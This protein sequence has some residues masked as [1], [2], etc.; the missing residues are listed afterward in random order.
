MK[1]N[2]TAVMLLSSAVSLGISGCASQEVKSMEV[3]L[4]QA[5]FDIRTADTDKKLAHLKRLQQN[6]LVLRKNDG[7]T[8]YYYADIV[9]CTC[10]YT[11]SESNYSKYKKLVAQ[12]SMADEQLMIADAQDEAKYDWSAWGWPR[13]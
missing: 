10:I 7:A 11:G 2:Y 6:K 13:W 12:E 3:L 4:F 8:G 1:R 9:G 5:G